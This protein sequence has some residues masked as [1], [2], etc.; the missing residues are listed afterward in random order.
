MIEPVFTKEQVEYLDKIFP[1]DLSN[2]TYDRLLQ[3][4]GARLVINKLRLLLQK[5]DAHRANSFNKIS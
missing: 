1:E 5:Q 2:T 3:R 4:Q